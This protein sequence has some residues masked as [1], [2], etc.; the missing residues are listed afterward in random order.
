LSWDTHIDSFGRMEQQ[1]HDPNPGIIGENFWTRSLPQLDSQRLEAL[2]SRIEA[3]G[4]FDL[5]N[6]YPTKL[7][8]PRV[9]TTYT[10]SA[11]YE[12]P[13]GT[14]RNRLVLVTGDSERCVGG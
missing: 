1:A 8:L 4:F 13:D 2:V 9:G 14:F 6:E 11:Q 3:A 5:Q 7:V 10:L 12:R